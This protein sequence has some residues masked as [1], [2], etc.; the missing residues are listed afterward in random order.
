MSRI[1]T[2]YSYKGG[3]GR[4][5]ALANIAVLLAKRGKRVLLMDWDLEAPGL[6]RYFQPYLASDPFLENGLIQLL[7]EVMENPEVGWEPFMAEVQID[8]S[9]S[10]NIISS[11]DQAADYV[12]RVRD[13]SWKDFFEKRRG[14]EV[15][16]RWRA[17]WKQTFDF[18]LIDSRTGITDVGGVCTV[19]L[20]DI[21]VL[22]FSTNEQSFERA[23]QI[24]RGVQESR[25][26]LA[27]PR[28]PAAILPLPGRF[29]GRDEVDEAKR[30]LDR[31]DRDLKLF[32]DDWLP[33]RFEPRQILEL[34]KVP[35]VAK[36]SFGEPLPVLTHGVSDPELPGFYFENVT[37]LLASDLQ[38]VPQMLDSA[39]GLSSDLQ[40]AADTYEKA[41]EIIRAADLMGWRQ[42]LKR[43]RPTVP[44]IFAKWR[45]RHSQ[46]SLSSLADRQKAVDEV[47]DQLAPLLTV[48]LAAVESGQEKFSDQRAFVDDLFNVSGWDYSGRSDLTELPNTMVYI[49]H[50]LHGAVCLSTQQIDLAV[51]LVRTRVM[52][53]MRPMNHDELWQRPDLIAYPLP[54]GQDA[55]EPWDYLSGAADRWPWLAPIFGP[56]QEFL[57]SLSAYYMVLNIHELAWLVAHNIKG[58]W[59]DQAN[60]QLNVPVSFVAESKEIKDRAFLLLIRNPA[61]IERLWTGYG[62]ISED[63]Q[64]IW[65]KW[66]R[67]CSDWAREVYR[68]RVSTTMP[69]EKLFEFL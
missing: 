37:R 61:S 46:D 21:L 57:I 28:P 50:S 59:L 42:L 8:E 30:W 55:R 56:P 67:V 60:I 5:F 52:D 66:L 23:I 36:F 68:L 49:Y 12:E 14:G 18:V 63:I 44:Q 62:L 38:D 3:V 41:I 47:V 24:A 26:K 51:Q 58:N 16:E 13:F 34:T 4:T 33:K 39:R 2:F 40:N 32:Y 10:V 27:V 11:G 54:L 15:L 17:E 20:P 25:R 48:A 53:R 31:F 7:G 45:Q 43:L 22:V 35:Y 64:Q 65:P 29:D 69:H 1:V 9:C 6:H 19:F